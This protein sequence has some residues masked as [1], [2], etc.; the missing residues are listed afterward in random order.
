MTYR[1]RMGDG[2]HPIVEASGPTTAKWEAERLALDAGID[3]LE[4]AARAVVVR[5]VSGSRR[6][7]RISDANWQRP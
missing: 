7:H 3:G 4:P 5:R 2:S 1:V 6:G